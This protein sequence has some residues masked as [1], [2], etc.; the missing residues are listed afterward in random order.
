M[1]KL[2]VNENPENERGPIAKTYNEL[3]SLELLELSKQKISLEKGS[4]E[5]AVRAILQAI[6]IAVLNIADLTLRA[7]KDI[8]ADNIQNAL[9][10]LGWAYD[11]HLLTITLSLDLVRLTNIN[12]NTTGTFIE[13]TE[14]PA[15]KEFVGTFKLF[16]KTLIKLVNKD[17][18]SAEVTIST[19]SLD[20]N[21]SR[22]MHLVKIINHCVIQ[23]EGNLSNISYRINC[24]YQAFIAPEILKNAVLAQTLKGDTFFT[25]FRGIHQIPETLCAEINDHLEYTILSIRENNLRKAYSHLSIANLLSNGVIISLRPI[26]NNLTTA[27]YHKIRENLGLTSGSHSIAL[28]Y[29]LFKDLYMQLGQEFLQL[30][31]VKKQELSLE[32]TRQVIERIY[33]QKLEN[34]MI[35]SLYLLT[36]EIL[37]LRI[38]T[39]EWKTIHLNL[40]RNNIGGGGT[41]SLIGSLDAINTAKKMQETTNENDPLN[42]V[43]GFLNHQDFIKKNNEKNLTMYM[44]SEDSFDFRLLNIIGNITKE[45][46]KDVQNRTGYFSSK[47]SFSAPKKRNI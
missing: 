34:E 15:Y 24:N 46:F 25:Q 40:P 26:T 39:N 30:L 28:H 14:S 47:S 16:D 37:E 45:R 27:D 7:T 13:I 18:S 12:S 36:K 33:D 19:K 29:H 9:V 38:F 4:A 11:F 17:D 8:Q 32:N 10:K 43:I 20:D 1:E 3:Q 31:I 5:S 22:L 23:W 44:S 42:D 2:D 41:K 35:F 21:F 6:E